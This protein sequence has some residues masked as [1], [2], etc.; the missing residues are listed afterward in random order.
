MKKL[1]ALVCGVTALACAQTAAAQNYP[2]RPVRI[3]LPFTSGGGTDILARLLA[4]RLTEAFGQTVLVDNRPG[5]GG[6]LGADLVAK[7]APDG[8]TLL[9]STTSTAV[10]ATLYSKLPFD[11]RKDLIAITQVARSPIVV[12]TH[13]SLPARN[14]RELVELSKKIAG[15][16]NFGSNGSGTVS[17]LAGTMLTQYS[18]IR[19][20]HVPYKG[21]SVA[22]TS[23]LSGEVEVE[24]QASTSVLPYIRAGK[25]RALAVATKHRI[26]ALPDTPTLDSIYPGLE[27]DQWYVVFTPAGTPAVIVNRLHAELV[28]ALQHADVKTWMQ[29][30]NSEPVGSSPAEAAALLKAEIEKYAKIVKASG[31]TPE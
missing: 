11:I 20:T 19:L 26:A 17:H 12:T 4:Q 1:L 9:F 21:A 30:E 25:L 7:S 16:L 10:N 8:L 28:K 2:A 6:N 13:P 23:L 27:I 14:V 15:G 24:F 31:A 29:R 3:I 22:V 18:G 5:A